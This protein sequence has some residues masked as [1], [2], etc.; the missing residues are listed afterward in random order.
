MLGRMATATIERNDDD[1]G[2]R[3]QAGDDDAFREVCHQFSGPLLRFSRSLLA[4]P[5]QARDAV[6][7]TLLQAWRACA[8]FDPNRPLSAWLF[9]ICRRVCI[10]RYRQDDRALRALTDTGSVGDLST[11]EPSIERTWT[12]WE[13]RRA[14]AGLPRAER[15]I[16]QLQYLEGWPHAQIADHLGIPV[17]TVQSRSFY[18]RRRLADALAHLRS[19]DTEQRAA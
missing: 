18:A 9:Q 14:I 12:A 11:E 15:V 3:F 5:E 19:P 17:G 13:V 2:A 8:R 7:Q 6:Q 16:V 10:D 1:L 4:D